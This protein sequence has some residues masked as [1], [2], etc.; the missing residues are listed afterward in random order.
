LHWHTVIH[1]S[2][3]SLVHF[4]PLCVFGL[5]LTFHQ[6][7]VISFSWSC[8]SS[9]LLQGGDWN[10]HWSHGCSPDIRKLPVY[11]SKGFSKYIQIQNLMILTSRCHPYQVLLMQIWPIWLCFP[12]LIDVLNKIFRNMFNLFHSGLRHAFKIFTGYWNNWNR[13]VF[14]FLT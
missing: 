7:D 13:Y 11:R 3:S 2:F 5:R 9:S 14:A 12:L 8:T 1:Q 10:S 6:S 4:N